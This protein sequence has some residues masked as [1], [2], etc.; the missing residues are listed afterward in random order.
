MLTIATNQATKEGNDMRK[1][2]FTSS[3]KSP[4][5]NGRPSSMVFKVNSIIMKS[6]SFL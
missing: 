5:E 6:Y 1:A 3:P 4:I 2:L